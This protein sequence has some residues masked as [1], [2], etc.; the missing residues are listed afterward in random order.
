[1]VG[2]TL[3]PEKFMFCRSEVEFVGFHVGWE[4]YKPTEDRLSAI[5]HFTMPGQPTITDVRSLY[6]FV[7][8]LAPFLAIAPIMEPFR[9]LLKKATGRKVYWDE[10][11]QQ[12]LEQAKDTISL[13]LQDNL[14]LYENMVLQASRNDPVYQLLLARILAGRHLRDGV[15]SVK[16][17]FEVDKFWGR[18]LRQRE[19]QM[20]HHHD[21]V[22]ADKS[23]TRSRAPLAPG[24]RVLVHDHQHGRKWNRAGIVIEARDHR[25]YLVR[26]NGSGR[27]SLRTRQHLRPTPAV[28]QPP[29]L[30]TG[31]HRLH[32]YRRPLPPQRPE[33]MVMFILLKNTVTALA[34]VLSLLGGVVGC[35]PLASGEQR[36]KASAPTAW[37]HPV[38]G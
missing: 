2:V 26:L 7:N 11:L 13:E 32:C 35:R 6:G 3:K 30:K 18:T 1:M 22:V 28:P 9:D 19:R 36:E 21:R 24:D 31:H 38:P 10:Q 20:A 29:T 25:Q 5:R 37:R 17:K 27:I 12:K 4:A 23:V 14:T 15:P 33:R 34:R 16:R 8:Q